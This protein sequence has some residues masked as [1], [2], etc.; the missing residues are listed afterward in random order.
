M[1]L[2]DAATDGIDWTTAG[3]LA[4]AFI[5][6]GFAFVKEWIVPGKVYRRE[7][8][9]THDQS[10]QLEALQAAFQDDFL[11]AFRE[12]TDALKAVTPLLNSVV[13]NVG[14]GGGG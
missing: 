6:G 13:R 7:M 3:P 5:G 12:S 8:K 1:S 14:A 9:R 11:P 2:A 4:A 10:K